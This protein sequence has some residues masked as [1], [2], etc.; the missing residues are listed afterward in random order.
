MV[1]W[2]I[3]VRDLRV[4]LDDLADPE[5]GARM[6]ELAALG[7]R[8]TAYSY[9][10]PKGA[11]AEV[12]KMNGAILAAWKVIA[13]VTSAFDLLAPHGDVKGPDADIF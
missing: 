7:Y 4:P 1:L 2:E 12:L 8:F 10:L 5:T 11:A 13:P 6:A 3:G 9:G